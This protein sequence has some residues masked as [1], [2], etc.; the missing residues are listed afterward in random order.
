MVK[1]PNDEC[2]TKTDSTMK[3]LC[4]SAEECGERSGSA[5]GKCASGFGICCLFT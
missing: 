2:E 5:D 1:F 4:V 3:G